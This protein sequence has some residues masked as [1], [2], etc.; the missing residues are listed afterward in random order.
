MISVKIKKE[1]V[2]GVI[3]FNSKVVTRDVV[4]PVTSY[5]LLGNYLKL[6]S[7]KKKEAK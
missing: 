1:V 6:T 4:T 3:T 5:L 2:K 7:I